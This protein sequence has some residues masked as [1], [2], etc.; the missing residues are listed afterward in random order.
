M[1]ESSSD[2]GRLTAADL[3]FGS[4]VAVMRKVADEPSSTLSS[5]PEGDTRAT[6]SVIG[7]ASWPRTLSM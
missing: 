2:S 3:T 5:A 6:L 4:R 1:D 7:T